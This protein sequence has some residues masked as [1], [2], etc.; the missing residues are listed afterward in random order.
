MK[1]FRMRII[2]PDMD[3]SIQFSKWLR[4]QSDVRVVL[5]LGIVFIVEFLQ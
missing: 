5:N 3:A 2:V 4:H 1:A